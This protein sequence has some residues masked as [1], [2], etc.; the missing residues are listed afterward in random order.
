MRLMRSPSVFALP[1]IGRLLLGAAIFAALL[2]V[3]SAGEPSGGCRLSPATCYHP[4]CLTC[5]DDYCPKPFPILCPVCCFGP[6]DYCPKPAPCL[7]PWKCFGPDD[8]CCKPLPPILPLC[9]TP[10]YT[11]G[12]PPTCDCPHSNCHPKSAR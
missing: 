7:T 10:C 5:P 1:V 12:P 6:D 11:C 4:P 9:P 3:A 2:R 8:Y